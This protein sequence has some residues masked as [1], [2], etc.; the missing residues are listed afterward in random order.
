MSTSSR[1]TSPAERIALSKLWWVGLLAVALATLVNALVRALALALLDVDPAFMPLQSPSF[2]ALTVVGAGAG[3][4][5]Y[6]LLGRLSRRP[7]TTFRLV[8]LVALVLSFLPDIGLLA[9]GVPGATW[10]TVGVLMFMHLLAA[11][12]TVGLLTTLA[13]E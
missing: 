6:W 4:G 1:L 11:L 13:R 3:V 12:I 8:A 9:G 7:I 10:A 5:V 2:V